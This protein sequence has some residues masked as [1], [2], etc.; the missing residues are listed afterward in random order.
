M[1]ITTDHPA[2]S[3]GTPVILDDSGDP[4]GYGPG[5]R[6]VRRRLGLVNPGE[7][8]SRLGVSGRT[9]EAWEQGK[10]MPAAKRLWMLK[11]LM[12]RSQA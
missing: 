3:Y 4:L 8:G 2:S 5:I 11:E 10:L 6:A 9:V 7:L 1:K 12:E